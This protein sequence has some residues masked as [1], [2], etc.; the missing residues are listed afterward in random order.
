[1]ILII[2]GDTMAQPL[3]PDELISIL[4]ANNG[5]VVEETQH[6]K[7][8]AKYTALMPAHRAISSMMF[9]ALRP[10]LD[11]VSV[12]TKNGVTRRTYRIV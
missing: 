8:G 9:M 1:M 2:P 6:G 10:R 11:E 5:F 4:K 7:Q 3:T 12:I